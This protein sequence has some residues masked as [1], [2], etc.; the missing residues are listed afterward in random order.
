MIHDQ[1]GSDLM[2]TPEMTAGPRNDGSK[3]LAKESKW[4]LGIQFLGT[5]AALGALGWI[6]S[7]VD[8]STF[9]G[10]AQAAGASALAT[11]VGLLTA[12]T[13]KNR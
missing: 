10:W 8:V 9:P 4:G 7:N 11:V 1:T 13:K 2:T 5:T 6:N 3:S 12:Y